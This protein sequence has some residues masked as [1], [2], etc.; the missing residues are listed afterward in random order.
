MTEISTKTLSLEEVRELAR[1][2]LVAAGMDAQGSTVVCG[3]PAESTRVA[4]GRREPPRFPPRV[5]YG[6]GRGW[7]F[8]LTSRGFGGR[9]GG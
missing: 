5:R 9:G 1:S 7:G 4:A 6:E 2:I 3:G 8:S